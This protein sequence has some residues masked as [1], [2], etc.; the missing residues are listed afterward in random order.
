MLG[1]TLAGVT[2]E[3]LPHD[4]LVLAVADTPCEVCSDD[5]GLDRSTE[6]LDE[7]ILFGVLDCVY[8]VE[9]KRSEW[10]FEIIEKI[11]DPPCEEVTRK[12]SPAVGKACVL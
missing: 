11:I 2:T 8:P 4:E 1:H 7:D 9:V 3:R 12:K 5:R 10:I 6:S